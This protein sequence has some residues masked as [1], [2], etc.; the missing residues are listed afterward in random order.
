LTS[1]NYSCTP[2]YSKNN[3]V[4]TSSATDYITLVIVVVIAVFSSFVLIVAFFIIIPGTRKSIF[5]NQ[6]KRN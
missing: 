2:S 1:N 4:E 5:K 3:P 6:K